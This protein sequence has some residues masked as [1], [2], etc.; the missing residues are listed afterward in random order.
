MRL[1][2]SVKVVQILGLR[3]LSNNLINGTFNNFGLTVKYIFFCAAQSH[4][5]TDLIF[6]FPLNLICCYAHTDYAIIALLHP[7]VNE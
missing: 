4:S 1:M 5:C 3:L 6:R 7:S 2:K